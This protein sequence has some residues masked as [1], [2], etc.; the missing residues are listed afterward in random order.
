M[1]LRNGALMRDIGIETDKVST[2]FVAIDGV[3]AASFEV[4]DPIKRGSRQAV[5]RLRSMGLEVVMLTGDNRATAQKIA[6][7]AGIESVVAEVLPDG[8]VA[9]IARRQSL[10]EVVA[11]VGDGVNDAPALAKADVGIA[12]GTGTDIAVEASDVTLMRADL[13][14]V[15]DAIALARQ[16]MRSLAVMSW[17]LPK[18]DFF[19]RLA[20]ESEVFVLPN[21]LSINFLIMRSRDFGGCR[22]FQAV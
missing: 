21:S 3:L 10:G 7:E 1:A 11:M 2:A 4:A 19:T 22:W 8:K 13:I 9:E 14:G 16:T 12:I 20:S 15:A 18:G 5:A 17:R 6:A